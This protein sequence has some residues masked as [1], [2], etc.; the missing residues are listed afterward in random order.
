M[1]SQFRIRSVL[2][3]L[4]TSIC[5]SI[6]L[7]SIACI[8]YGRVTVGTGP[9]A[10]FGIVGGAIVAFSWD[11]ADWAPAES[12]AL[13]EPERTIRDWADE[14]GQ[15]GL[16]PARGQDGPERW[17][18]IPLWIPF[19]LFLPVTVWIWRDERKWAV[20][21]FLAFAACAVGTRALARHFYDE[22]WPGEPDSFRA[23]TE[24]LPDFSFYHFNNYS[25]QDR[26][27]ALIF[28]AACSV[29]ALPQGVALAVARKRA[30]ALLITLV[31]IG[32]ACW[33]LLDIWK[34]CDSYIRFFYAPGYYSVARVIE[35]AWR[36]A[37]WV[38]ALSIGGLALG[39]LIR[40]LARTR[41]FAQDCCARCGYDLRVQTALRIPRCP[42]CGAPVRA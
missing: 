23:E 14:W 37:V 33:G 8:L 35:M 18:I 17:T 25:W 13:G 42:E 2:K 4:G 16:W 34:R 32:I 26:N 21:A 40:R 6:V 1:P 5:A 19:A 31:S 20:V 28:L 36:H 9:F 38:V 10:E 11:G 39:Y 12:A 24:L 3:W 29:Y 30:V 22:F 41:R 27:Q 15:Y 7:M